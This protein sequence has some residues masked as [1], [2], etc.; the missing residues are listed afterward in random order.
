M[1]LAYTL[2][3]EMLRRGER[4]VEGTP[5]RADMVQRKLISH[6][7]TKDNAKIAICIG[8]LGRSL[9]ILSFA[10]VDDHRRGYL[11]AL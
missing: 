7:A 1:A 11:P 9:S 6:A 10:C 4:D 2:A 3:S 8:C 5:K